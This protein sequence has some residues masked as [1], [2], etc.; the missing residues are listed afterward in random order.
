MAAIDQRIQ[1]RYHLPTPTMN[2]NETKK[3]VEYHTAQAGLSR[4][5]SSGE[6]T[7]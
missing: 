4:P 6:R 1:L 5:G 2:A 3:Y 7:N